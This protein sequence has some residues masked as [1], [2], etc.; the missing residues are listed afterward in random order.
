MD[1]SLLRFDEADVDELLS[2]SSG[3]WKY[4]GPGDGSDDDDPARECAS[5]DKVVRVLA[6]VFMVALLPD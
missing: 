3:R 4:S 6:G 2:A 1:G 5:I